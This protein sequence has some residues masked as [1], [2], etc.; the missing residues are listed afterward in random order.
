M[1]TTKKLRGLLSSGGPP[2]MVPGAPNALTARVVEE[3]GFEAVYVTG[4]GV[5]NSYLGAPDLG[6]ITLSELVGHVNA[7]ADAVQIPVVV[8]GDT[9]FGNALNVQ[10]TV[11]LIEGAGAAALQ[12]EDQVSPKKCGHFTGK[13]VISADEMVGKIKAAVDARRDDD[14]VIIARTDALA[15]EGIDEAIDRAGRYLEAGADVL[16]V[17]APRDVDQMR[18][19]TTSVPGIHMA[20]MV[21]GGLTP[22]LP[23]DELGELGFAVA[24]YANAAMRGAVAGMRQVMNHLAEIGDTRDAGELMISWTDRQALVRKPEFD[25]LDTKYAVAQNTENG[26]V[27]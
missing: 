22:L 20:N 18:R 2:L 26:A 5:T 7:I 27:V 10:R 17:E 12:L 4:A 21:E 3:T 9:G 25:E 8:D 13:E 14:F 16:F 23:R 11:R 15:I 6:L 1:T 19:I 24:L